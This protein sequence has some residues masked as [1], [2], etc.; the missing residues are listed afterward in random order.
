[1]N[2][3]QTHA[4]IFNEWKKLAINFNLERIE[5]NEVNYTWTNGNSKTYIDFF[6]IC[7]HL[8]MNQNKTIS[9]NQPTTLSDHNF[10]VYT[11]KICSNETKNI[12]KT[13]QPW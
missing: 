2:K 8:Q 12:Y 3:K 6:L 7:K 4:N 11:Y 5:K 1:M 13:F 10:I 9:L